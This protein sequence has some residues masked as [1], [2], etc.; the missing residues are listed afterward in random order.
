MEC[1]NC[2]SSDVKIFCRDCKVNGSKEWLF[3]L[4]CSLLHPRIKAY[5]G[6]VMIP[7]SDLD[8]SSE[9]ANSRD[10][11]NENSKMDL[12]LRLF[13]LIVLDYAN[14]LLSP[15]FKYFNHDSSSVSLSGWGYMVF[16]FLLYYIVVKMM[17]GNYSPF[18]NG[19]I[20]FVIYRWVK[21]EKSKLPPT[22]RRNGRNEPKV[23]YQ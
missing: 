15:I 4:G 12:V 13:D 3:C 5:R 11:I 16:L 17:C 1:C 7:L 9:S 20:F 21:R 8:T 10:E 18:V 6:H 19:A 22:P 23:G 14:A 2:D